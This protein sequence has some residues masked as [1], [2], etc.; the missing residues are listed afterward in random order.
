MADSG[1]IAVLDRPEK[2]RPCIL[3]EGYQNRI[4]AEVQLFKI[5]FRMGRETD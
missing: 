2:S 1:R 3:V 4:M 5:R